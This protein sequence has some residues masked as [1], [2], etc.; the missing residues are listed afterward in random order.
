M[1]LRKIEISY[2][3]HINDF[4]I[5][6]AIPCG[7]I[8]NELVSNSIKHAFSDTGTGKIIISMKKIRSKIVLIVSDNGSGL[9]EDLDWRKTDSFGLQILSYLAEGQLQGKVNLNRT[10]GTEFVI[11][12]SR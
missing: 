3:I 2:D 11:T 10:S 4:K 6:I 1:D 7:F 9:P 5:D 8:I 12:F